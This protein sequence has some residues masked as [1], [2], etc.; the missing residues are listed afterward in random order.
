[1]KVLLRIFIPL[2][3]LSFIAFGISIP[4]LGTNGDSGYS[5][6][7][8]SSKTYEIDGDYSEIIADVGAYDL[9]LEPY[10]GSTTEVTVTGSDRNTRRINVGTTGKTLTISTRYSGFDITS[11]FTWIL[12]RGK[13]TT[14]TVTVPDKIYE[15]MDIGVSSGSANVSGVSAKNVALSTTS[16]ELKYFQPD[17]VT[18][19]LTIKTTSGEI[20]A[21]NAATKSYDIRSTSGS[22]NVSALTG[23]GNIRSTSGDTNIGFRELNGD[24]YV[25]V[26]SGDVALGL[27]WDV[28]AAIHCSK[29]S[30]DVRLTTYDGSSSDTVDLDSSELTLGSGEHKI[31]INITSGDVELVRSVD[32]NYFAGDY[33]GKE[34]FTETTAIGD[35]AVSFAAEM[36]DTAGMITDNIDAAFSE[37][38]QALDSAFDPN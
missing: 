11:W 31:N 37:V 32:E 4:I 26:T 19:S 2:G 28:S 38:E 6:D 3:I 34:E 25:N 23:T 20:D 27:P 8:Y 17:I 33:I 1:M 22:I 21:L 36:E 5:S 13:P 9:I 10:S 14:V 18:D 30:G 29:T 12:D 7:G 24:C 16:G 15:K 35:T